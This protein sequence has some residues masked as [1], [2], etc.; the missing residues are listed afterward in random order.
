MFHSV[1][2]SREEPWLITSIYLDQRNS[3]S[4]EGSGWPDH[5]HKIYTKGFSTPRH[6]GNTILHSATVNKLRVKTPICLVSQSIR[7]TSCSQF[8]CLARCTSATMAHCF[9]RTASASCHVPHANYAAKTVLYELSDQPVYSEP[10][11]MAR[12]ETALQ[13]CSFTPLGKKSSRLWWQRMTLCNSALH[14][15]DTKPQD[16]GS[17]YLP[18]GK[19]I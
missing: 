9:R 4:K 1:E 8:D 3:K 2:K 5:I 7:L 10:P 18:S 15:L 16:L 14:Y 17:P 11:H 13:I 12:S 6:H 19:Y